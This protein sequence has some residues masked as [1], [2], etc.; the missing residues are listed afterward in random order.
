MLVAEKFCSLPPANRG[1][2]AQSPLF[3]ITCLFPFQ[4]KM[5]KFLQN[6]CTFLMYKIRNHKNSPLD[7]ETMPYFFLR[8]LFFYLELHV[9]PIKE[10]NLE[11][12]ED[13]LSSGQLYKPYPQ[14]S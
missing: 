9:R 4:S 13:Q 11:I 14:Y 12:L 8:K 3:I 2:R 7:R 5:I 6:I 1:L 10:N